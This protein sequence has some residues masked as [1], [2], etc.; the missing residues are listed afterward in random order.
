MCVC[1]TATNLNIVLSE[2]IAM[3]R[4]ATNAERS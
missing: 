4:G 2:E 1:C 3:A